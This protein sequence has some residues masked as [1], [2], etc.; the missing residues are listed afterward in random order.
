MFQKKNPDHPVLFRSDFS[1]WCNHIVEHAHLNFDLCILCYF[2]LYSFASIGFSF[3]DFAFHS[4]CC[5]RGK[6]SAMCFWCLLSRYWE[7]LIWEEPT[8]TSA[9]HQQG[10]ETELG[11]GRDFR[12]ES[13]RVCGLVNFGERRV[14]RYCP[15][16]A[17]EK[18]IWSANDFIGAFRASTKT[19]ILFV[20]NTKDPITPLPCTPLLSTF[21]LK[22]RLTNLQWSESKYHLRKQNCSP[23]TALG[24]VLIYFLPSMS[25]WYRYQHLSCST[26]NKCAF[27]KIKSYFQ[28]GAL[29]SPSVLWYSITGTVLKREDKWLE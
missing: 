16:Y 9:K 19:P 17:S 24:W 11:F 10:W 20:D 12:N 29:S 23:L 18:R 15:T 4:Y 7:C 25:N 5:S 27:D 13:A 14:Y 26:K 8:A 28:I 21:H 2:L 3:A 6:S 1:L 22:Q